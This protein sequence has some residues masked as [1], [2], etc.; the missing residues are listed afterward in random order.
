[1]KPKK[2]LQPNSP[3]IIALKWLNLCV[4]VSIREHLIGDMVE[5]F[6]LE[7]LPNKG[8]MRAK[9]WFWKQTLLTNYEFLNKQKGGI[10]AFMVS[11]VVF[12]STLIMAMWLGAEFSAFLNLPSL[13]I[14]LVPAICFGLAA[15]S[16]NSMKATLKLCLS[17]QKDVEPLQINAAIQF[18][19][20]SGNSGLLLG[21][22]GT[23]IGAIAIGSNMEADVFGEVFG[24]AFAVCMLTLLYT[25]CFKVLCYVAE[26]KIRFLYLT[27]NQ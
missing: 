7:Q 27:P 15:T 12:I 25:F 21:V 16:V 24:P 4:P 11:I 19:Q 5:E 10:M 20:V 22:I 1:M 3:P 13:L 6:Q 2:L 8:T 17:E 23:I 14:T 18:L 9:L 26:Q